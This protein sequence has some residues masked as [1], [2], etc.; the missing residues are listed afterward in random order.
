MRPYYNILLVVVFGVVLQLRGQCPPR[1]AIWQQ[2]ETI[3]TQLT[4]NQ[5]IEKTTLLK[6]Q[7][8]DCRY[9]QDSVYA[10]VIHILGRTYWYIGDLKQAKELTQQAININASGGKLTKPANCANSYFNLGRI[11]RLLNHPEA[12]EIAFKKTIE[13]GE[14]YPE[15]KE[16][17]LKAYQQLANL[18]NVRG[19]YQTCI[20]YAEIGAR[21]AQ[22]QANTSFQV[23]NLLEKVQAL[24]ILKRFDEAAV[25]IKSTE[26]IALQSKDTAIIGF[27]LTQ[28]ASINESQGR[29]IEAVSFYKNALQTYQRQLLLKPDDRD[30]AYNCGAVCNNMANIYFSKFKKYDEAINYYRQALNYVNDDFAYARILGNIANTYIQKKDFKAAVSTYQDALIKAPIGYANKNVEHNPSANTI[31]FSASKSYLI[32]LISAKADAWLDYAKATKNDP[33]KLS[34]AIKTYALADSMVDFMR[35]EQTGSQSKLFWRNKTRSMYEHALEACFLS[36]NTEQAFHFLEKS[37]AVLLADKLNELG[38][39][40]QLSSQQREQ[41]AQ[42]HQQIIDLQEKL[43]ST[44]KTAKALATDQAKL[45]QY[46]SQWE[47]FVRSLET[48]N[49]AYYRYKYDNGVVSLKYLRE[50]ILA[51]N[52][53][54]VSFFMGDSALYALTVKTSTTKLLKLPLSSQEYHRQAHEF[55]NISAN[56][57]ALNAHYST[58]QRLAYELYH[59]LWKPIGVSEQRVIVA[60]DGEFLPFEALIVSPNSDDFLVKHQ[61]FSYTYSARFLSTM[62]MF[63]ESTTSIFQNLHTL[64]EGWENKG[65]LGMAPVSFGN[66]QA[67]LKGSEESLE[68]VREHFWGGQ[69]FVKKD[70]TKANFLTYAPKSRIIQLFTHADADSAE[71]TEPKIYFV[72]STLVLSELSRLERFNTDLLVLSACKTGVG[73][74]QRGEGVYSLARG[75]AALGILSTVTTLW[76]VEDNPTYALT[77]S[78]YKFLQEGLPKDEALQKAKLEWLAQGSAAD[79]LPSQWAGVLLVGSAAALPSQQLWYWLGGLLV[80][81]VIGILWRRRNAF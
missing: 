49:P 17:I 1:T 6:K 77:E 53:A 63:Q 29:L 36:G 51:K 34:N 57:A 14:R 35:W 66:G 62:D 37:K 21:L 30:A 38:A 20:R 10:K 46:Q 54:F 80:A 78:F 75:F 33:V 55:L 58:F 26:K 23:N 73:H 52:Q 81:I 5:L 42:L 13:Y 39:N 18:Y 7:C 69:K 45:Y 16:Q 60:S 48:T 56:R 61:A 32:S 40:Q 71:A 2:L 4:G 64:W 8:E 47:A 27:T 67:M 59:K 25:L 9:Q 24:I 68:K 79:K 72:D 12:A 22:M 74:N 3:S 15:R 41:E 11:E 65:F 70:A 31:R 50:Q 19:D 28:L 76:Q 44:Q 43:V